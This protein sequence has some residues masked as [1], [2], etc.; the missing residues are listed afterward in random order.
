MRFRRGRIHW[1][2]IAFLALA[3]IIVYPDHVL[4]W[5][6][7]RTGKHFSWRHVIFLEVF[8]LAVLAI[9]TNFLLPQY[10]Q[11]H[12]WYPI[13]ITCAVGAFR[14]ITWLISNLFG[15]EDS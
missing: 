6:G 13:L 10:P 14:L 11:V 9:F 3:A 5:I 12:W 8:A 15:F 4:E 7:D 2:D 1:Y